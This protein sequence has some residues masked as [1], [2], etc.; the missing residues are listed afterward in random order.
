MKK[1]TLAFLLV[2]LCVATTAQA[3]CPANSET[4]F[5]CTA[6][7]TGKLIEVCATATTIQYS[8][9]R[10]KIKSELA[11]SVPKSQVST[12][13]W[14]GIGRV[15]AYSINI[16]NG[17]V[18]YR[19]YSGAEKASEEHPDGLAFAGV[20]VVKKGRQIADVACADNTVKSALEGLTLRR[21]EE[22]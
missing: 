10:P 9:G 18:E 12:Y 8:L 1:T 5:A 20:H 21:A 19:V 3:V 14:E 17:D 15:M 13:Q 6:K 22:W 2:S 4:L 16:P 7:K 11:L